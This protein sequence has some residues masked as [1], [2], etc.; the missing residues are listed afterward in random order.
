MARVFA[1]QSTHGTLV[2]DAIRNANRMDDV[3]DG[4]E[5]D[6]TSRIPTQGLTEEQKVLRNSTPAEE[7]K[8]SLSDA[9]QCLLGELNEQQRE[10]VNTL[11]LYSTSYDEYRRHGGDD[12]CSLPL[13][14]PPFLLVQGGPGTGSLP[15]HG[16]ENDPSWSAYSKL[17]AIAHHQR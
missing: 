13:P 14:N 5:S 11:L 7:I 3:F 15:T 1:F 8:D 9:E 6:V 2:A 16:W 12:I 4:G 10:V 17:G